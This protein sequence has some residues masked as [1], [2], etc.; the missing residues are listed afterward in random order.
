VNRAHHLGV[1][2][3]GRRHWNRGGREGRNNRRG[4][5]KPRP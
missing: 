4:E 1:I 2:V 3:I 5:N